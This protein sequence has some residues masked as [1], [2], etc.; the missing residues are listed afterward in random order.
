MKWTLV[1]MESRIYVEPYFEEI[2]P[3][4]ILFHMSLQLSMQSEVSTQIYLSSFSIIKLL[5]KWE[6]I[7]S[8]YPVSKILADWR[9]SIDWQQIWSENINRLT[10]TTVSFCFH[11]VDKIC[12]HNKTADCTRNQTKPADRT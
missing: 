2:N 5:R 9:Q 10:S 1:H 8:M 3:C 11:S 12:S 7:V 4:E 6:L